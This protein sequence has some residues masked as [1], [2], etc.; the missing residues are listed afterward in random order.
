[1]SGCVINIYGWVKGSG[2][3]ALMHA[4]SAFEEDVVVVLDMTVPLTKTGPA[5][6]YMHCAA[7]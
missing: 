7:P 5:S 6:L 2:Y 3:Q 1:V 4:A